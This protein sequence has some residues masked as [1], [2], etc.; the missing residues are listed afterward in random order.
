MELTSFLGRENRR[1]GCSQNKRA[2]SVVFSW[3]MSMRKTVQQK[4]IPKIEQQRIGR[5]AP[6]G[7]PA[8][9]SPPIGRA[10]RASLPFSK[11]REFHAGCVEILRETAYEIRKKS[12]FKGFLR[13]ILFGI[14]HAK[15][16]S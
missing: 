13:K 5:V 15:G 6:P 3:P 4:P 12:I 11:W 10:G 8:E 16:L 9:V 2:H 7:R 14:G 1:G